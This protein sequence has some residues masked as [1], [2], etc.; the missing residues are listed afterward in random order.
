[1]LC[2]ERE[3]SQ[4][5]EEEGG[6]TVILE[7]AGSSLKVNTTIRKLI[8]RKQSTLDFACAY[9]DGSLRWKFKTEVSSFNAVTRS[10]R[11]RSENPQ[12]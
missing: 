3:V 2:E 4:S 7:A 6:V 11:R 1:M 8:Q 12:V 5:V 10:W 9:S